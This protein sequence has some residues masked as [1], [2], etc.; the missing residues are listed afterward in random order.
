[1]KVV[2]EINNRF[3]VTV[4]ELTGKEHVI[5]YFASNYSSIEEMMKEI[6][7]DFL[8]DREINNNFFLDVK[9]ERSTNYGDLQ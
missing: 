7:S 4:T 9:V 3:T 5:D 6:V 2:S 1:M 8:N